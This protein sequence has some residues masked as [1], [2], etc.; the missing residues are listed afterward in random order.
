MTALVLIEEKKG[1]LALALGVLSV[2]VFLFA[3]ASNPIVVRPLSNGGTKIS[4]RNEIYGEV[5]YRVNRVQLDQFASDS[6]PTMEQIVASR[7]YRL[8]RWIKRFFRD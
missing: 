6:Q 8:A 3:S 7:S 1:L 2:A 5:F 4:I